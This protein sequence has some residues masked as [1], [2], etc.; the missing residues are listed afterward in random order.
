MVACCD[1]PRHRRS[2]PLLH[3][4]APRF[5]AAKTRPAC[6]AAGP[7]PLPHLV[8]RLLLPLAVRDP[9]ARC[10]LLAPFEAHGRRSAVN[11][12]GLNV[13]TELD[14]AVGG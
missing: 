2:R 10:F 4:P 11:V 9:L 3:C 7:F 13:W 1:V 14:G 6:W 5:P 12:A 8:A